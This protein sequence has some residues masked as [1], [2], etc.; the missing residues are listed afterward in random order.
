MLCHHA[1][2]CVPSKAASCILGTL[3]VQCLVP[4]RPLEFCQELFRHVSFAGQ[5]RTQELYGATY[6]GSGLAAHPSTI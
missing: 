3:H 6:M 5:L 1:V 4:R 2:G